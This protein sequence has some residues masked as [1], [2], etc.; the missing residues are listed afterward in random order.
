MEHTHTPEAIRARLASG[1]RASYLRDWIYGGIDGSVTTFAV[2]TGVAGARLSPTIILILGAANLLADGFSMAASNFT[3][4]RTERQEQ[5]HLH[6]VEARHIAEH[7]DGER[8][9]VRQILASKGFAGDELDR[10][11]AVITS[12]D[13]RWIQFMLAEEYGLPSQVRSAWIAALCTFSAFVVCGLIPLLP[14]VASLPRALPL[15][16]AFTLTT[17]FAIG[18]MRSRW[19]SVAWWRSGLETFAIGAIA[20]ALAWGV[21]VLLAAVT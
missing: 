7:P 1:P 8:E 11:V 19:L 12:N 17:F 5:E 20:A 18:S 9:E 3:A 6:A 2:V 14:F 10:A 13:E 4:T 15:S 16:I 21:G